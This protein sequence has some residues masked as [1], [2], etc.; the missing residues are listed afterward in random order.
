M[1]RVSFRLRR[2]RAS[3][4]P[5]QAAAEQLIALG[6][7][8]LADL[9]APAAL[10]VRRDHVRLDA[11]YARVLVVIGYPRSVSPGWLAPLVEGELPVEVSLHI[12]PLPSGT[13]VRSLGLQIARLQSSLSVR[14]DRPADPAV[15]VGIEDAERLRDRLQRGEERVF[16]TSLYL[17]LR[18]PSRQ[19]LDDLTRGV[20]AQLDS[21]LAQSRVALFEQER[22][23]HAC[24]PECRDQLLVPRNLD[25]TSLATSLPLAGPS[26][27]MEG[28]V[29]YGVSAHTQTPVIV[30]PFDAS[31]ENYNG[32]VVAPTGSGK[33]YFT[34]LLALRNR[35]AG[36]DFLVVDPHDEY[37]PVAT[38]VGGQLIRL[39]PSCPHRLNPFDLPP[40]A[41]DEEDPLAERVAALLGWLE[42]LLGAS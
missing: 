32:L 28:G 5:E 37:G 11:H 27:L 3:A 16:S 31:L 25:T 34:K 17:L 41:L 13:M 20:E 9:I 8:R 4:T 35:V 26:L 42:V 36:V 33:S 19:A 14:R 30:D 18:A 24:L 29:L 38:A 7:R 10:E 6:G 22:G 21:L 2:R 23:L 12:R 40:P 15:V 39:A 1:L